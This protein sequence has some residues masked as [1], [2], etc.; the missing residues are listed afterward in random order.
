MKPNAN[1]KL[2]V[3][4]AKALPKNFS[5]Y[6]QNSTNSMYPAIKPKE[7]LHVSTIDIGNVAIGD[8]IAFTGSKKGRIITHRV[9]GIKKTDG[10]IGLITKGDNLPEPDGMTVTREYFIGI[11]KTK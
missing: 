1:T 2:L 11:V 3:K 8:I 9:I 7:L 4:F 5:F 6:A 10:G